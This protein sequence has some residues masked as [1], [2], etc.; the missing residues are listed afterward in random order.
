MHLAG[1]ASNV[2]QSYTMQVEY[3]FAS[4]TQIQNHMELHVERTLCKENRSQP[5][6]VIHIFRKV[7]MFSRGQAL[8]PIM[9]SV[10]LVTASV[11]A[12]C[13]WVAGPLSSIS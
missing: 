8:Y 2:L 1:L 13:V 6:A 3:A 4:V 7:K 12:F 9:E 5:G 10:L 11:T